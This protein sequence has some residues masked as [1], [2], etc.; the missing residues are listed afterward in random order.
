MAKKRTIS[1]KAAEAMR[2]AAIAGTPDLCKTLAAI[3]ALH[4]KDARAQKKIYEAVRTLQILADLP[5]M[6]PKK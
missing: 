3:A 5:P 1:I 2:A 6:P 4:V